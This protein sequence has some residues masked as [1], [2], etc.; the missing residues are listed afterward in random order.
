MK[1]YW[2][3]PIAIYLFLGGLGGGILTFV[4]LF[5]FLIGGFGEVFAFP[6]LLGVACLGLGCFFLVF[7]LGQPQVFLRVFTTATSIIK[8]GA[9]LLSVALI[10]GF[11]W[12]VSYLGWG[13][14]DIFIPLRGICLGLA[15]ITGALV[16]VY[17]G[18]FLA[19]LKAHAFWSTPALPVLFT[20]SAL[21]TGAAASSLFMGIWPAVQSIANA[22]LINEAH[23]LLHSIDIVLIIVEMVVLLIYV[24]LLRGSGND[25]ARSVAI[26]WM[27]GSMAPLFWG[28]MLLFG[29]LCPLGFYL[30]GGTAAAYVAPVLVMAAGLL[31]RFM[32]VWSDDRRLIP[33]E[34]RFYERLPQHDEA[35]LSAWKNKENMY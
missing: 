6:V 5:E 20:V 17:T 4:A 12:F 3:W 25:T 9:V 10:T 33:G 32:V 24:L 2:T 22:E 28:G 15:G 8:W 14:T 13:W 16:M 30:A 7:E 27:T 31:L 19:S 34:R 29:L 18:V 26:R 21:S 1:R 35:F 23:E 11:V